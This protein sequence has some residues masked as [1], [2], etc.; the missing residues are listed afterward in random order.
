MDHLKDKYLSQV[1]KQE[2]L[3][4]QLLHLVQQQ[5][6]MY[7]RELIFLIV[8]FPFHHQ[9]L[10]AFIPQELILERYYAV[11]DLK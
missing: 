4:G 1:M 10:I 11:E 3:K 6:E 2:E 7:F 8:A 9:P 5:I